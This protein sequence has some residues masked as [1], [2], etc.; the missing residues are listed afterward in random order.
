MLLAVFSGHPTFTAPSA[1]ALVEVL[2]L[3][4]SSTIVNPTYHRQGN[5]P[6]LDS[7]GCCKAPCRLMVL[8]LVSRRPVAL[9]YT[10]WTTA[11]QFDEPEV[12]QPRN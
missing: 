1:A 8:K 3:C 2:P 12:R 4:P 5:L 9:R 7:S 11:I 6:L 10:N